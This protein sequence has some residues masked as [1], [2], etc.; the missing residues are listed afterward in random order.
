[1]SSVLNQSSTVKQIMDE[2]ARLVVQKSEFESAFLSMI[3]D[4]EEVAAREINKTIGSHTPPEAI[5]E[6]V[7]H[8]QD[9][10]RHAFQLRN[11][12]PL[13]TYQE[14][15]Y[16]HLEKELSELGTNFVYGLLSIN[17]I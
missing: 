2:L 11:L 16:Y 4:M 7:V 10:H 17:K 12:K 13:K 14:V 8:A 5:L 3:G 1:M 6:I 15:R 9:E